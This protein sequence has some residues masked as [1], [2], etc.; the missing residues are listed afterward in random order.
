MMVG[1]ERL[2]AWLQRRA[3]VAGDLGGLLFFAYWTTRARGIELPLVWQLALDGATIV[4]VGVAVVGYQLAQ[5]ASEHAWV[6]WAAAAAIG[7]GFG[8]SLA[9]LC[10]GLTM[11][12]VAIITCRVH[13]RLPGQLLVAAGA[14]LCVAQAFAPGFGRADERAST[15]WG[16]VMGAA[17]IALAGAMADLDVLRRDQRPRALPLP[18]GDAPKHVR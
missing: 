8:E 4:L 12:G 10:A 14:V 9:L 7:L 5:G 17:L 1:T 13:P 3:P 11:F 16:V 6:G 18:A 15:V 2:M